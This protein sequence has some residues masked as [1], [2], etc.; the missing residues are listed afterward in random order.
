M[1]P[2]RWQ[3]TESGRV[4]CSPVLCSP[5]KVWD[6]CSGGDVCFLTVLC[7][8]SALCEWFEC[9]LHVGISRVGGKPVFLTW[10]GRAQLSKGSFPACLT[11]SPHICRPST[12]DLCY[13]VKITSNVCPNLGFMF[14]ARQQFLP[15]TYSTH[16]QNNPPLPGTWS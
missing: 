2:P 12:T 3:G 9:R 15:L 13:A 10:P 16:T 6:F 5:S 7:P 1:A 4:R 14:C 8:G 11:R